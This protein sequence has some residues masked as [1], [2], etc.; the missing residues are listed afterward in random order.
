MSA[1]RHLFSLLP[2][3]RN[4]K[5]VATL[6]PSS[7]TPER[8][9]ALLRAGVD[10]FRLNFSHGAADGHRDRA[11]VIRRLEQETARPIAII[12][13]LQ[14][15]K[16]RVGIF[17]AGRVEIALGQK[18]R[19][20]S[21]S[22][23]G[24]ANRVQLPHPELIR[25]IGPGAEILLDDGRVR[26]RVT[27]RDSAGLD[28]EVMA[29]HAISDR[30]GVNVP[31][32]V[33][34]LAALT[35]KDR[36]DLTTAL[37][38]GVDWVALSFVQR[39][40]DLAEPRR[41]IAGR[42][43]LMVKL[44]KP[45]ALDHLDA[46]IGLADGIMVARGDLGVELPPEDV[47]VH[48]RRIVSAARRAGKPVIVAT[49]MLESMISAPTP[50]R[51]EASDVATAVYEGTDAVMLSAETAAGEYPV[52]A[53]EMMDRIARR[54]ERDPGYRRIL[55]SEALEPEATSGDAITVAA[56]QVARTLGAAVIATYTS[57]GSTTLRAARERPEMPILCLT[58][59]PA[60]ARRLMLSFGVRSVVTADIHTFGQMVERATRIAQA[61]G[62][63]HSGQRLV[64]TAG[65]PFGTPGT[66]NTLRIA[67]VE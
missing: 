49:Q 43:A 67:W 4:T 41:L 15:P 31:G 32:V 46:L 51:A 19:L 27:G 22:A 18:F 52:E 65:V 8:I 40:E 2:R 57:S 45:A 20:D 59:N 7:G 48:Q 62:L 58:A 56:H 25:A 53:V 50:T 23:P 28:T 44:E 12:A 34:P 3:H 33:L 61:V 66:T 17:A 9:E 55:D 38:I 36:A 16:L 60:T 29:G 64:I 30:K 21:D 10:A 26:L 35:D 37:D 13:D 11:E 24:D 42:A 5:I 47:P 1:Q 6:G 54:V 63:A 39:P 14:G